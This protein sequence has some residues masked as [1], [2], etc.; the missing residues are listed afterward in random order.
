MYPLAR[1]FNSQITGM[2]LVFASDDT[3]FQL[4]K[5][6]ESS[7]LSTRQASRL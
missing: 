4:P 7:P 3:T 2:T 1:L 5:E 6:S